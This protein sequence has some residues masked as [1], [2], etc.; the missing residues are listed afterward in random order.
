MDLPV[1]M[2]PPEHRKRITPLLQK[3]QQA[4]AQAQKLS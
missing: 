2:I 1:L 4:I 3:M